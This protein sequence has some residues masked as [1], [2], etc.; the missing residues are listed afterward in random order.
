MI[1]FLCGCAFGIVVVIIVAL[2]FAIREMSTDNF[3]W[4]YPRWQKPH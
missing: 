4:H 1:A 3:V 2:G